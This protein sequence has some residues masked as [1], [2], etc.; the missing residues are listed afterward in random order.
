MSRVCAVTG[1]RTQV[2]RNVAR[3]GMAKKDG[4]V[5]VR[6]TGR[7]KRTFKPNIHTV[8]VL[9]PEGR[10]LFNVPRSDAVQDL[11]CD[12]KGVVWGA[13]WALVRSDG[14]IVG[15]HCQGQLAGR[16]SDVRERKVRSLR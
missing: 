3:R 10:E 7:T 13:R 4:G 14:G 16:S 2:G 5:G 15:H 12:S 11:V 8:R 6:C 9:T 1:R